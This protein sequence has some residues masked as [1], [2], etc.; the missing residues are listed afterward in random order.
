V[1]DIRAATPTAAAE[2]VTPDQFSW[3][4]SF[5][6]Y[7]QRL[8]QLMTDKTGRYSEKNQWLHRRLQQQHP[9]KQVQRCRQR[10]D[11][12]VKRLFRFSR[13]MLDNRQNKLA[14]NNTKLSAQSPTLRLKQDQQT[15][16]F[17]NTRLQQATASLLTGKKSRLS[18]IAR[19][20]NAISPLQTLERGYSITLDDKGKPIVSVQQVKANDTIE[21]RLFNGSIISLVE[22]CIENDD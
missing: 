19:T 13:T 15:I 10:S 20:L 1:A 21:T 7:Q 8:Q 17:L 14:I 18:N 9:E 6:W 12:L 2:T 3:R 4:Q 22:S 11:E 5:D 16:Q